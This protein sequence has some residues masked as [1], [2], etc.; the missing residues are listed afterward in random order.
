MIRI[1]FDILRVNH[2]WCR[3]KSEDSFF[4]DAQLFFVATWCILMTKQKSYHP[5]RKTIRE[6]IE[7]KKKKINQ[8]TTTIQGQ[9]IKIVMIKIDRDI[10]TQTHKY[11]EFSFFVVFKPVHHEYDALIECPWA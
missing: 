2:F 9:L 10:Y 3:E 11:I 6:N 8:Y 1:F 5:E 4:F 7:K